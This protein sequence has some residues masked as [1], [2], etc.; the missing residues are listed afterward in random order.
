MAK[1]IIIP[2]RKNIKAQVKKIIQKG[3]KSPVASTTQKGANKSKVEQVQK[4]RVPNPSENQRGR[5][6]SKD[7]K[8]LTR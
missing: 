7:E 5:I 6:R 8:D 4:S 3:P 1:K 2:P